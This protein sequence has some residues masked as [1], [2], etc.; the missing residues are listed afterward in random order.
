MVC[1]C[2]DMNCNLVGYYRCSTESQGRSG[3]G[4]EAQ[5]SA[6]KE[7]VKLT[8]CEL[9]GEYTEVESSH[10]DDL[11]NRPELRKAIR[12]AKRS[13][14][15]LVIAKLDRLA[16]SVYVTAELMRSGV[17][18]VACD[19][20]T[21]NRLT[22]QI[23]AVM[24]E[25]EAEQISKRTSAALAAYKA[26]GGLLGA[27]LPQCRNLTHQARL[28]GGEAAK[29]AHAKRADEAYAEE[30]YPRI[31]ALARQDLSLRAIACT[32]NDEGHQTL[33]GKQWTAV[34]V[35]RILDRLHV[36]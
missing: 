2:H 19:N 35:G 15:T 27:S 18:F 33:N 7:H 9:V 34:Q 13:K 32:L 21:A 12:H 31:K 28:K 20:P 14:A 26:R 17:E 10:R 8:G 30:V 1:Y 16:R 23:L 22:I 24:A 6:V 3:L 25:H 5:Q 4:L 29:T 11:D 36:A